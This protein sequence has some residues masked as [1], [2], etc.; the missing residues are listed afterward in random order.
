MIHGVPQVRPVN[1]D[2]E[3]VALSVANP[4][5]E[6]LV[7]F[8]LDFLR[9]VWIN[10]SSVLSLKYILTGFVNVVWHHHLVNHHVLK[11]SSLLG[12]ICLYH[13]LLNYQLLLRWQID[14][15]LLS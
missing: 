14:E 8:C 13:L 3:L 4:F 2:E 10:L 9:V 7:S 1:F 5:Q 6:S 11:S 15:F 12:R